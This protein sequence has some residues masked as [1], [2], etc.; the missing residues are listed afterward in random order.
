M[1]PEGLA[2]AAPPRR[3]LAIWTRALD[4][5]DNVGGVYIW[6]AVR[7]AL[8]PLGAMSQARLRNVFEK[9]GI[10]GAGRAAWSFMLGLAGGRPLPLQCAIFAAADGGRDILREAGRA[11]VVYAD[12]IRTL[13]LLRRLRR[14]RPDLRIVVDFQDL[15]SR[16]FDEVLARA[17]PLPLGYLDAMLP[18]TLRR[19]LATGMLARLLLRYEGMALRHAEREMLRIADCVTLVSPVEAALLDAADAGDARRASV[20]AIPPPM[21]PVV[22]VA[23][24]PPH[25]AVF[26]GSDG[27]MQNRLTI[28]HLLGLWDRARPVL[29]L[30][31]YGRQKRPPRQVPGV[32]WA[33]YVRDL[34]EVYTPGSLLVSP[35]FLRGGIKTKVL[36]AFAHGVP[37]IG[38]PATFEG[39]DLAGY[40]FCFADDAALLRFLADPS[41]CAA[42]I[43]AATRAARC[44]V[45]REY[46]E[47]LFHARWAAALLGRAR[48]DEGR[49]PEGA[50]VACQAS[51]GA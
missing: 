10:R 36:E 24:A 25:R 22:P 48:R 27:L 4:G 50:G 51:R 9:P 16:R 30:V 46:G 34:S 45:A 26:I 32:V 40:P 13:L 49:G 44:H 14:A 42:E 39:M 1:S 31:I 8:A 6:R 2:G 47:A 5:V 12:G 28:D 29:P 41:P 15:M 35:T 7:G 11:D 17:L 23:A 18:A 21:P 20:A 3:I 38:N 37:V 33:G 19:L 43:A